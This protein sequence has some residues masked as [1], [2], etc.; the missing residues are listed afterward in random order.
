MT[1]EEIEELDK[2]AP[3]GAFS[4]FDAQVLIPEVEKLTAGEIYMEIGVD[5]GKSLFIARSVIKPDIN[6]YAVDIN[7]TDEL[8]TYL[9]ENPLLGEFFWMSSKTV[10]QV[11][12]QRG[13][14]KI[15]VLFIDGDH[16][17]E[18]CKTDIDSWYPHM[19]ENGVMLF[20]DCDESSPGV[21]QAVAEFVITQKNKIKKFELFKR[22]DKNTSMAK[23]QL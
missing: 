7:F 22:T 21:M 20:H 10:A 11:W 4:T 1:W 18:G 8:K 6:M 19:A 2:K 16:S 12:R 23:I 15:Y 17:Y 9:L 14:P 13:M 3:P 5:K